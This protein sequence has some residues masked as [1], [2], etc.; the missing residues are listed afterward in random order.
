MIIMR[1]FCIMQG[2]VL[3]SSAGAAIPLASMTLASEKK[4]ERCVR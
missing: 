3:F 4:T 1:L 2:C